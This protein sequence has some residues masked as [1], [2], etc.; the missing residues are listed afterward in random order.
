[1]SLKNQNFQSRLSFALAGWRHAYRTER[2]F[3]TH[4]FFLGLVLIALVLLRPSPIWWA[5]IGFVAALVIFAELMNSALEKLVDFLHPDQH[6]E[7]KFVKDMAAGA[8]LVAAV[9]ALWVAVMLLISLFNHW[10]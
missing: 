8:V 6:P 2:S 10:F 9:A 4:V 1:M 5:L 7:I 3:R